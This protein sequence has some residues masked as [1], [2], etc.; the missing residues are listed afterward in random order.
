[1]ERNQPQ[2]ETKENSSCNICGE[3][4]KKPL[5]AELHSGSIIEEYYACP[6]CLTK[7]GDVEHERKAEADEALEE[8]AELPLEVEE[9]PN[10]ETGKTEE[11]QTCPNYMGYLRKRQKGTPIPEG[12]LTCTKMIDCF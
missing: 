1:V 10:V 9:T 4:F 12:C 7:V 8:E 11:T 6:R 2:S 5:L 3:E